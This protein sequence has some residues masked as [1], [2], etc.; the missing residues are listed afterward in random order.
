[1]LHSCLGFGSYFLDTENM[2]VETMSSI[3]IQPS[4]SRGL[5]IKM[6]LFAD[7]FRRSPSLLSFRFPFRWTKY[8]NDFRLDLFAPSPG[9]VFLPEGSSLHLRIIRSVDTGIGSRA[10]YDL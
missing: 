3:G 5:V 1:M 2:S 6:G 8:F 7:R 10:L 9:V 4:T